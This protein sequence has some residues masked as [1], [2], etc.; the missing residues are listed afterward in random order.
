[1]KRFNINEDIVYIIYGIFLL[2][3]FSFA[4]TINVPS[5]YTTI[6]GAINA[7]SDSDEIIVSPGTYYE[8]IYFNGKNIHLLSSDPLSTSVVTA[9]IIDGN[10][11]GSVVTFAGTETSSCKLIGFTITNGYSVMGGGINGN[12][13][14]ANIKYSII[15]TNVASHSGG[16]ICRCNG[17]IEQNKILGNLANN[18]GGG[19]YNCVGIIQNNTIY[20]NLADYGGGGL[21]YCRGTIQ[22]NTISDNSSS[23]SGG[24][25]S[26]CSGTIQNNTISGNSVNSLGGG[27]AGC[28]GTI[29]NNIISDNSANYGG[30]IDRCGGTIQNNTIA[31]NTATSD[32]GGLRC[33]DGFIINCIIWG[34]SAPNGSQIYDYCS[35]PF[36]SCI[37]DWTGGG[38]GNMAAE[39]R[40]VDPANRNYRLQFDSPCIDNGTIYYLLGEYNTDID[41]ECRLVGASGDIGSD[42]YG[43]SLDC[44][45]DLLSNIDETTHGSNP[46][47]PDTDGDGLNDGVEVLRGTSPTSYT[48]PSGISIPAQYLEIQKGLF[49]S[50]PNELVTISPGIYNE[51]LHFLGKNIVLQSSNPFDDNII[52]TT[53]IDG[54]NL[55]SVIFFKGSE[56]DTCIVKGFTI[57]NGYSLAAGG[58]YGNGMQALVERNKIMNNSAS[59][60]GGGIY[61]CN[62]TIQN[63]TISNNYG[64]GGGLNDCDGTI[65][66][67]TI[68]GNL[69]SGNGGGLLYCDGTIQNNTISDNSVTYWTGG[70]LSWCGGTIQNNIISGNSADYGGGVYACDGIIQNNNISGNSADYG[71]GVYTCD[72]IIQNNT[73]SNNSATYGGGIL[74]CGVTIQNNT[75]WNNSATDSGGGIKDCDGTIRNCIVWQNTAPTGSQLYNSSTPTYSCIQDWID[76]GIGN[77]SD[78]PHL[79][80]PVNGDFHLQ[81]SSPC[82]DAG[83][84]ISG[85]TKDFEGDPR[86]FNG[87]W[88]IRGDGSDYDIGA[89]E[90]CIAP[91]P[92]P[93]PTPQPKPDLLIK[94]ASESESAYALD[95][96]YQTIPSGGQIKSQLIDSLTTSTFHVK[97]E[98]DGETSRTFALKAVE[99]PESG[100]TVSYMVNDINITID[101][102]SSAGYTTSHLLQGENEIITIKMIPDSSVAGNTGKSIIIKAFPDS[103]D[104]IVWDSVKA[105]TMVNIN[106]RPD[107]WLRNIWEETHI[108]N[109]IYESGGEMQTKSQSVDNNIAAKYHITIENDGNIT[110]NF[111]LTGTAGVNGWSVRYYDDTTVGNNITNQVTGGGYAINSL[112]RGDWTRYRI[113]VSPGPTM[114]DNSNFT[115]YATLR[116]AGEPSRSDTVKM[117]THTIQKAPSTPTGFTA[118]SGAESIYL[119]WNPNSEADLSGYNLYRDEFTTGS[120][121]LINNM[122]ITNI[123]Y[124][125][126]NVTAE[127]TYYYKITAVDSEGW[128]SDKSNP[129][130]ATVGT[131]VVL[132]PDYRGAPN[133]DV[134]LQINT[135]NANKI[136]G[137]GMDIQVTYDKTLLTPLAV[138]K[139][140]L[141]RNVNFSSNIPTADGQ[142][143]ITST[144][145]PD[146]SIKGRGHLIDINFHISNSAD[147]N[148]TASHTFPF[149]KLFNDIGSELSVDYSDTAL[150]TVANQY[151]PG[152]LNGDGVVNSNDVF[153]VIQA[154]LGQRTLT[155]LEF[156]AADL[157]GDGELSG[158]DAVMILRL[159]FGLP[160]NPTQSGSPNLKLDLKGIYDPLYIVSINNY[161]VQQEQIISIPINLNTVKSIAALDLNINYI[162]Q[163]LKVENVQKTNLTED[164]ELNYSDAD[165]VLK[166]T[167]VSVDSMLSGSGPVADIV[168]E[169]IG[170]DGE[171]TP[172]NISKYLLYGENG[173]DISW[174]S[175]VTKRNGSVCVSLVTKATGSWC[176]YE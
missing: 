117:V 19:L 167:L 69:S 149:V 3:S 24:G 139:T 119:K 126:N 30:G 52:N 82:I 115:V 156:N 5:D 174:N 12:G 61:G 137:N 154:I 39:P 78:E 176:L 107:L 170:S 41:G 20:D 75:I 110:D 172:L 10:A 103:S 73:I 160:I 9:T 120:F 114:P 57:R 102:L 108:G 7:S 96:V 92:T 84:I 159:A 6:Q 16:G 121:T 48:S 150:F 43:S 173:D 148:T 141:T 168:F 124:S 42:E 74:S 161:N 109:N 72:G 100:W 65:Q 81:T 98:N 40:F 15:I 104:P 99:S 166:I 164:F 175:S 23:G 90:C 122:P 133:Q 11:V 101:I 146:E 134:F 59:N 87:T 118:F 35:P 86:P 36:Y 27:L 138:Q 37:Q 67:N 105:V 106:R 17:T 62:G 53:I 129:E 171:M 31:Y 34:N 54:N 13:T 68:S 83:G 56:N 125:D 91:I 2:S 169:V 165:G 45:G 85:L 130:S 46:N 58:I 147:L 157:N 14:H 70:G 76:G 132:M 162:P 21:Y 93:I 151:M 1:M 88:Y 50:F 116:S 33:C 158:A 142:I 152:D 51:N 18:Y 112:V 123:S 140:F 89:D 79:A 153:M 66:N 38:R 60:R 8:N 77:I 29:Q 135:L 22:N 64:Y 97:I 55:F 163:I 113:E 26:D 32:G 80:D 63:N 128:E 131:I 127:K 47:I 28:S 44:D 111:I 145:L 71:G 144:S 143:N 136:S 155:Q 25:L 94:K 4:R 49:L 95:N